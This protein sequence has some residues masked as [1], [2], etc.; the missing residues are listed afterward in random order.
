MCGDFILEDKP[1]QSNHAILR[2]YPHPW[3]GP[4]TFTPHRNSCQTT[5]LLFAR[6][7]VCSLFR[8]SQSTVIKQPKARG[9]NHFCSPPLFIQIRSR[10]LHPDAH[11]QVKPIVNPLSCRHA[12]LVSL[13]FLKP[14][15]K[16]GNFDL[17]LKILRTASF[18]VSGS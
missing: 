5:Q 2:F 11:I 7:F 8:C 1:S 12:V 10:C 13:R 17:V 15:R 4:M 3:N 6:V 16:C 18:S 14:D 9:S